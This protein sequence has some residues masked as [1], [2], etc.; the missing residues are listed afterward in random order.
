MHRR[1]FTII[2]A[3]LAIVLMP[4]IGNALTDG[5]EIPADKAVWSNWFWPF[6]NAYDP[7][8]YD[9]G[10]AMA[11]YDAYDAGAAA[12]DWEYQHHGP[13]LNP[14]AWWGHCHAWAAAAC[15][16]EQPVEEKVLNG[17]TFRVRD[18][19]GLLTE[20]YH[21]SA[22]G[23]YYEL[24]VG[25]PS[26]GLFWRYL[27]EEVRGDNAL[28]GH[29]MPIIG[30][31]AYG[32]EVWNYPIYKYHV[33]FSESVPHSGTITI[34]T[35]DDG[36]PKYADS[37]TLHAGTFTYQ[38]KGVRG[39]GINPID[40]GRWVGSGSYHRPDAIWRPYP[41]LTW[42][43]YAAN[44][45]IDEEHINMILSEKADDPDDP[46]VHVS[47]TTITVPG[48]TAWSNAGM[49]VASGDMLT[50]AAQGTLIFDAD[51]YACSPN[52]TSWSD[53]RDRQDPLWQQPHGGVIGKIGE[54]G[55]PF[56]IGNSYTVRAWMSGP[57]FVG[58]NDYWYHTNSGSFTVKIERSGQTTRAASEMRKDS[59]IYIDDLR[60]PGP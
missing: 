15:W 1:V 5:G 13:P 39:D 20:M 42:T 28:H 9:E 48:N 31:L 36:D 41:A 34:W 40:S 17:V 60:F 52:G 3:G 37:I 26:P 57:L 35:A 25:L 12:Q 45:E 27:R 38:F 59:I 2:M 49:R 56:F 29:G 14:A 58:I 6:H 7:N 50:F 54:H 32:P 24:Y 43:Q 44:P 23:L 46:G 51:G 21:H 30:E 33:E 8:L 18:Q 47:R 55:T 22:D 16:E 53:T 19:K 10:E 4:I 11:R